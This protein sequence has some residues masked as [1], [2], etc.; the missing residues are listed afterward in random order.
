MSHQLLIQDFHQSI[1]SPERFWLGPEEAL[2]S[3]RM[4]M[5]I[6]ADADRGRPHQGETA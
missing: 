1:G 4:V 5:A 6:Y 3:L 2:V